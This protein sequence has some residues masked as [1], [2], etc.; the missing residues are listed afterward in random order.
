MFS[1]NGTPT[2][3]P[4]FQF[5]WNLDANG[6]NVEFDPNSPTF[7]QQVA[8]D[9]EDI[10]VLPAWELG[11]SGQGV[12]IAILAGGFDL[13][14]P[15]LEFSTT[16]YSSLLN[17]L[18]NSDSPAFVDVTDSLGTALAGVVGARDNGVGTIGVAY[19]ADII[20][21]RIDPGPNDAFDPTA[22]PT[23][24]DINDA[25]RFH[26]GFIQDGDGDGAP[27]DLLGG[28]LVQIGVDSEGRAIL[29][30]DPTLV[31][32]VF[33][34]SGAFVDSQVQVGTVDGAGDFVGP[35]GTSTPRVAVTLP[36][37][38]SAESAAT[39]GPPTQ[40][41]SIADAIRE[42]TL[43]GRARYVDLDGDGFIG[44]NEIQALGSI[45]VVPAGNDGGRLA[46]T[47]PFVPQ[48]DVASSQYNALANSI[49]TITVGGIDYDGQFEN[50]ATGT[51]TGDF[52]G[53][54]N[55]L[56]VVPT[57]TTDLDLAT[58]T[59][60]TTGLVTTDLQGEDGAN[61]APLFNFEFRR[62]LLPRHRLHRR[63]GRFGVRRGADGGRDRV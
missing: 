45:H 48:G 7:G 40:V 17:P 30:Q 38:L 42:T 13:D 25:I 44:A 1:V 52:E 59:G 15:D 57:G 39:A 43:G 27:D 31:T 18:G 23:I 46:A 53:G 28:S 22:L 10:N 63:R 19:N 32:D 47:P 62:R 14:H 4:L 3:E 36:E 35:D 51:F 41:I 24:D 33:L 9:G 8:V 56:I 29:A 54:A 61:S 26:A 21:I 12:Q 2:D 49:Y 60:L 58:T 37:G 50:D 34:H 11:Y 6:Q 16:G 5:Q 55:V 20:P